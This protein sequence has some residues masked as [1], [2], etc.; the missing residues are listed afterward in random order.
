[1]ELEGR[2][3]SPPLGWARGK[4]P[5]DRL[6]GGGWRGAG[7]LW[8]GGGWRGAGVLWGGPVLTVTAASG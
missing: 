1:M 8:G 5:E 2:R 7:V 3:L 4:L 6:G